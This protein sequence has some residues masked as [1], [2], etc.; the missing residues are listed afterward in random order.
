MAGHVIPKGG[1]IVVGQEYTDFDKGL[2][3][4]IEGAVQGFNLVLASAFSG[5]PVKFEDDYRVPVNAFKF[6]QTPAARLPG[7]LAVDY[8][9]ALADKRDLAFLGIDDY[10]GEA[11][12]EQSRED[13]YLQKV[14]RTARSLD[15]LAMLQEKS[16]GLRLVEESFAHC[17]IGRGS[18][19][20]D[21]SIMLI[22]WTRTPVRVFGGAILKNVKSEQCGQ[23]WAI[24]SRN[25]KGFGWKQR[26][27]II[28]REY[29]SS[30]E[31]SKLRII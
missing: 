28:Y 10:S 1:D 13:E 7:S 9:Q 14:K 8:A 17:Q 16:P 24:Y 19:F 22:S 27:I 18:P 11:D 3:D 21:E 20:I 30:V 31:W 23:F 29:K 25:M 6:P 12:E 5:D 26:F 2:E 15:T 4:G